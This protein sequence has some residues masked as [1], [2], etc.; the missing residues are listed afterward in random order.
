[1]YKHTECALKNLKDKT[2]KT[3]SIKYGVGITMTKFL[4][5][6]PELPQKPGVYIF[7]NKA[8][9]VLYVGKAKNLKKR[10]ASYFQK[11][12][13]FLDKQIMFN[14]IFKIEYIVT[15]SE[16][17]ALLLESN[18]IKK[19]Q[20]RY[21]IAFKDDKQYQHI[22]IDREDDFPRIYTVRKIKKDK[23]QYFGP[24]PNSKAI[25]QTLNLLNSLFPFRE[26]KQRM[27][28]EKI[29][30]K[31]YKLCLRH[32]L[33]CCEAPCIGKVSKNKY[34]KIIKQCELFLEGK[35]GKVLTDLKKEMKQRAKAK[36]FEEAA[37]LRDQIS[38]LK[39]T[40]FQK[41]SH[42]WRDRAKVKTSKKSLL[43]LMKSLNLKTTPKRIECYD[44]S[45]LQG[46]L[47]AGS[48]VVFKNGEPQKSEYRRFKIRIKNESND[49]AMME[50]VLMRRFKHSQTGVT[51][52]RASNDSLAAV[53]PNYFLPLPDLIVLDGGKGQ[54][55][56]ALKVL[57][58]YQL[59]IPTVALAKRNEEIY[60]PNKL[61]PL[62]L[63]KNSP[64]LFLLQR[65]RDKAHRFAIS[66]HRKLRK[67]K[68]FK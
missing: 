38:S 23:A 41:I 50:E 58:K 1:M 42:L 51:P 66:Y 24:F 35:K 59:K 33:G 63:P 15:D 49:V 20:P 45:N 47:A 6:I 57:K 61:N 56:I 36:K 67:K 9:E 40:A 39:N 5:I 48:M 28:E 54:L 34:Q 12:N 68:V 62:I 30:E 4:K 64:A 21:N 10:L 2:F 14:K 11:E 26:C 19:Y 18:L 17:E 3:M 65:L 60:L 13:L 37:K 46:S 25:K 52:A 29:K 32:C 27:W 55:G 22:K 44:I 53:T 8:K 7:K 43:E 31:K 16:I